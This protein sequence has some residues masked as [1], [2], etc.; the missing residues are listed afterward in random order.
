VVRLSLLALVTLTTTA[1]AQDEFE[2][3][4]YDAETAPRGE[5]GLEV[6]V[7]YHLIHDAADA[8]HV[9]FEPHYGLLPWLEL[10]GYLQMAWNTSGDFDFAGGK[11]R[12]KARWPRR[13]WEDRV[14]LAVNVELSAIPSQ[15]EPNTWGSEVR[16]IADLRVGRIYAAIN[17]ILDIDLRG[18]L[19]GHP[20]LQPAAK[21][22]IVAGRAMFG[23]EA[24]GAFGP[25]DD[26]GSETVERLFGVIDVRGPWWDLN[27]GIG[28]S[29]GTP[30]HPIAKLI[31]GLHPR[32]GSQ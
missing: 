27:A 20:Q 22:A 6:H 16:P 26:L 32:G 5:P 8:L 7:N 30:D 1:L 3:Q 2:I 10:G 21:F 24:Y 19:A 12:A 13:V 23:I 9:T 31:L 4:V 15:F 17:P 29:W 28:A 18:Q 14:G 25:I 11:L